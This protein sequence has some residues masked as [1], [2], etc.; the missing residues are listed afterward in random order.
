MRSCSQAHT[1]FAIVFFIVAS[2]F[3]GYDAYLFHAYLLL[4][5]FVDKTPEE[6]QELF[7]IQENF[8]P[9]EYDRLRDENKVCII[10]G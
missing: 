9:E 4:C 1:K 7:H 8:S 6:V 2:G 10:C 5:S 3:D